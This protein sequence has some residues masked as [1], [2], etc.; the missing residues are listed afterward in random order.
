MNQGRRVG[1]KTYYVSWDT[2]RVTIIYTQDD[3][4]GLHTVLD[5]DG[6]PVW[7]T[8]ELDAHQY[9]AELSDG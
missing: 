8:R 5:K 9:I 1:N 4:E 2:D 6:N 7:F 3:L